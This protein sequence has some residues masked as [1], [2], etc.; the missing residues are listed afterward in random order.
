MLF[1]SE[2]RRDLQSV[3][4]FLHQIADKLAQIKVVL[5]QGAEELV[6][7]IPNIVVLKLKVEE[8][9]KRYIKRTLEVK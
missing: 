7:T 4:L 2:E 6:L 8:E 9:K 3:S 1:E 5:R